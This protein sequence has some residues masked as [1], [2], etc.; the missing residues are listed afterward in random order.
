MGIRITYK[1][2]QLCILLCWKPELQGLHSGSSSCSSGVF[3]GSAR[4]PSPWGALVRGDLIRINTKGSFE[5][6]SN[7]KLQPEM[8]DLLQIGTF[9]FLSL[10]I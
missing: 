2:M 8:M 10:L 6:K 9:F 3:K 5:K 4:F 7:N 1:T